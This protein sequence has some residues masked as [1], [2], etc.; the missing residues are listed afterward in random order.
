MQANDLIPTLPLLGL[1][2]RESAGASGIKAPSAQ[3]YLCSEHRQG[4]TAD[5]GMFVSDLIRQ[6][7]A[8]DMSMFSVIWYGYVC[9]WSD[10]TG[11]CRRYGYVCQWSDTT[12]TC[13]RYGYVFQWSDTTGTCR[14]YEY[15]F[16]DLIRQGRAADM[17]MFVS[18][19]IRQGRAADM[20]MF[21]VI[22]Y[23]RDVPPI[24]VCFQWSDM[25]MFVSDLIRQ[26]RAADMGMFSVI[27][28]AY[29][30]V[31]IVQGTCRTPTLLYYFNSSIVLSVALV[32]F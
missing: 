17:G 31:I 21:S 16:S 25:G 28:Y 32:T 27:W 23:D 9:Q 19:L 14:R 4:R 20:G 18:D 7:R 5:M 1:Q 26:G 30:S 2:T 3:G 13:R 29:E 8:A 10:T 12:G 22:W 15:V 6:G 24:W 11:T